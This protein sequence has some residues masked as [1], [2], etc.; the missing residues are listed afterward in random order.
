MKLYLSSYKLGGNPERLRELM[1]SNRIGYIPN[2]LDFRAADPVKRQQHIEDDAAALRELG[3][4][5]EVV[6]L[7]D[8]FGRAEALREK[9]EEL[10]AIFISGGNKQTKKPRNSPLRVTHYSFLVSNMNP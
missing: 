8:Y 10:G 2:A 4:D 1:S 5:V 3:L 7:K 9:L 6:D